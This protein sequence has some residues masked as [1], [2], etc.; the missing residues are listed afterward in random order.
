MCI[1]LLVGREAVAHDAVNGAKGL[2]PPK[3]TA[4]DKLNAL[5]LPP[6]GQMALFSIVRRDSVWADRS[7][8]VCFGPKDAVTARQALIEKIIPV[9]NEWTIGTKVTFDWG[10]KPY[11]V[12][13]NK[14]SAAVRVDIAAAADDNSA[15]FTS[16]V[17]NQSKTSSLDGYQPYSMT[18][19]F[20]EQSK[21]FD[22]TQIFRFY[23]L[24]EFGHALG[25]EHEHQ[26]VDCDFDW[27]YVA[28]H[29]N[30]AS[31]AD[32]KA[33]M[34]KIFSSTIQAYPNNEAVIDGEFITTKYDNYSVMKY[35][36]STKS[37]PSGDDPGIYADGEK[38]RCYRAG[39]VSNLTKFDRAGMAKAYGEPLVAVSAIAQNLQDTPGG[40][41][42]QLKQRL[43]SAALGR[44]DVLAAA[45]IKRKFGPIPT[46]MVTDEERHVKSDIDT[47]KKYPGAISA[48]K[49]ALGEQAQQ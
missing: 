43:S 45:N 34:G 8:S 22:Q 23:V 35:N 37:S 26:R 2:N 39:W 9:A 21:Y 11:R 25:F 31:V 17:G 7:I 33:S 6:A 4:L 28:D 1:L 18:L 27:Q 42:T 24:H 15:Y 12:C 10:A 47:L 44:Q 20:P 32:A 16:L 19:L 13:E 40:L 14:D 3:T 30:F 46:S 36:L 41:D 5:N 38:S 29:F 49:A 48:L